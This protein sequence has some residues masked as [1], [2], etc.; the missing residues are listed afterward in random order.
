[1]AVYLDRQPDHTIGQWFRQ[2]RD[3][4]SVNT[5]FSGF[6][7]AENQRNVNAP[8]LRVRPWN[9][10]APRCSGDDH[11]RRPAFGFHQWSSE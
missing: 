1:M 8:A 3:I 6:L 4:S 5:V 9:G 2:Q 7:R 11:A 10:S